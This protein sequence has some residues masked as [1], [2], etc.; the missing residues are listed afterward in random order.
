MIYCCSRNGRRTYLEHI[1][2]TIGIISSHLDDVISIAEVYSYSSQYI[3]GQIGS[4][5]LTNTFSDKNEMIRR[6]EVISTIG[7]QGQTN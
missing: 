6:L 2:D 7:Q 1:G 5:K 4:E 3:S